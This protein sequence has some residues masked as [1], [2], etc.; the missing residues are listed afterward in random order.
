MITSEQYDKFELMWII[1][2][3]TVVFDADITF[4]QCA[5]PDGHVEFF[6]YQ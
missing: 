5:M 2:V 6:I 3:N 4:C 1:Y